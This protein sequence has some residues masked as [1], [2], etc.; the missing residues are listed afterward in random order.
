[1]Q[2]GRFKS[3]VATAMITHTKLRYFLATVDHGSLSSA[4]EDIGVSQP[5]MSQQL[6]AL[7]AH[8]GHKLLL[9][10]TAGVTVTEAGRIFYRHARTLLGQIE[11]AEKEVA[12][13]GESGSDQVSLGLATCGAASTL[14]MPVLR[15]IRAEHPS[16]RLR[17]ND[18]FA[19]TLSE[20]IM[21]GRIDLALAYTTAP[22]AGVV[23]RDLFTEELALVAPRSLSLGPRQG[24]AVPLTAMRDLPTVLLSPIHLL[25]SV[26]DRACARAGFE[27]RVVAEID[28]VPALLQM[29]SSGI[30]VTVL[31]RVALSPLPVGLRVHRL[32][33]EVLEVMVSL[34]TSAHL[35]ATESI[36]RV[37]RLVADLVEDR[38]AT[39]SWPGVRRPA[40]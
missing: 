4:A 34:C 15:R 6:A 11:R 31:P 37:G 27:P 28:S 1:M 22:M 19:G 26:V 16:I 36:G 35:P 24:A 25:R 39:G 14:A 2:H 18:N 12:L 33:P 8:L 7:E 21:T 5:T 20:F 23:Y 3:I 30:G 9:R 13:A 29:V 38:L 17:I 32:G 40:A 10:T